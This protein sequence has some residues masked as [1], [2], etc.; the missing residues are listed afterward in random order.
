MVNT[1]RRKRNFC[2]DNIYFELILEGKKA[3]YSKNFADV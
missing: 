2:W 1:F 3:K